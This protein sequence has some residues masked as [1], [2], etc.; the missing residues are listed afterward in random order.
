MAV[1]EFSEGLNFA[2][3]T[4]SFEVFEWQ[5]DAVEALVREPSVRPIVV[6]IKDPHCRKKHQRKQREKW[7]SLFYRIYTSYFFHP[8]TRNKKD[9]KSLVGN[10]SVIKSCTRLE[11]QYEY[12]SQ[13]DIS[14]IQDHKPDFILKLGFGELKGEI[15]TSTP[16]GVWDYHYADEQKF[17]GHPPAFWEIYTGD[18]KT[19]A[20][21]QRLTEEIDGGVILRKGLFKTIEHSWSQNLR[22][23]LELTKRWPADVCREI[24]NQN[25]FPDA[26]RGVETIAP[27][28]NL[29]GNTTFTFFLLK[30]LKNKLQHFF[31]ELFSVEIWQTG[32]IKARTADILGELSYT[33]EPVEVDWH[34]AHGK[35]DYYADSFALRVSDR[36]LLL[37]E[38]YSYKSRLGKISAVWFDE[39]DFTFSEPLTLLDEQWHLSYPFVFKHNNTIYCIPS[40]SDKKSIDLYRLD[41]SSMKLVHDRVLIKGVGAIDPTLIHHQNHWFLFF[42]SDNAPNTEL[43]I[44]HSEDLDQEFVPHVLN[45]VKSNVSNSRPAGPLFYLDG[46]LYRPSQDCSRSYGGR[47]IIH[48]VKLLSEDSFLEM[49]VSVLDP[50]SGFKGLHNISFA[51]DFMYFDVKRKGFSPANF[52]YQIKRRVGLIRS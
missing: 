28:Y 35:N 33:I 10:L 21:L 1:K 43:H 9:L 48:E 19:G 50:P 18:H 8:L 37:Y 11:D 29:P 20:T 6:I 16:L 52:F 49:A 34:T 4:D 3:L 14:S 5:Y 27:I 39:R 15:L 46:N 2:I 41:I 47:V 44:W 7:N 22:Q 40:C 13:E 45:P 12:F 36:L 51:S 26:I 32:I 24:I 30:L 23:T 38:D 31:N 42:T 25:T 17:R